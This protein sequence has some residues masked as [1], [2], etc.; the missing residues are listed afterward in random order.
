M[1]KSWRN[2]FHYV[3]LYHF[4]KGRNLIKIVHTNAR[5][6][7]GQIDPFH[8][9]GS[10][11]PMPAWFEFRIQSNSL[12]GAAWKSCFKNVFSISSRWTWPIPDSGVYQ[13]NEKCRICKC[14][15]RPNR[16]PCCFYREK[17]RSQ[18][19]T[20][21]HNREKHGF[22]FLIRKLR[23]SIDRMSPPMKLIG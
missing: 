17:S 15:F 23:L 9:M 18:S 2:H 4:M 8:V 19:S 14:F 16:P 10:L 7:F 12:P 20:F 1:H 13:W 11:W 21:W 5:N 22:H 6:S 3:C